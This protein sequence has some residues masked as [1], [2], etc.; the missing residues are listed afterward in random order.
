M[1][2]SFQITVDTTAPHTGEVFDSEPDQSDADYQSSSTVYAHWTGFF[3]RESG[4]REYKYAIYTACLTDADFAVDAA[5]P[6]Q[7][8]GHMTF[9]KTKIGIYRWTNEG[10]WH[11]FQKNLTEK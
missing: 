7:V 5:P 3:D 8:C 11:V 1:I 9:V 6:T 4:V 2:A 10:Q